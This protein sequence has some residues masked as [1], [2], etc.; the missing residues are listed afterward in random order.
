MEDTV[1]AK[2]EQSGTLT[3]HGKTWPMY[4]RPVYA[5]DV[6]GYVDAEMIESREA[7]EQQLT[8]ILAPFGLT[9]K[10]TLNDLH[11]MSPEDQTEKDAL[12]KMAYAR[13]D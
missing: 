11:E 8:E 13:A 10:V 4:S 6:S 1:P 12:D 7:F 3:A 2:R 5:V 9:V